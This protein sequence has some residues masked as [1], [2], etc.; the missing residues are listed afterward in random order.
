MR[1][2]PGFAQGILMAHN[3]ELEAIR[4]VKEGKKTGVDAAAA[5][6]IG[7]EKTENSETTS[8]VKDEAEG[9]GETKE[10]EK[11]D[12]YLL[13]QLQRMMAYLSTSTEKAYN[14]KDWCYSFKDEYGMPTAPGIQQDAQEYFGKLCDRIETQLTTCEP[15]NLKNLLFE[16]IF[17]GSYAE[18]LFKKNGINLRPDQQTPFYSVSVDVPKRGNGTLTKSLMTMCRGEIMSDFKVDGEIFEVVKRQLISILPNV[19]IFHLKRFELNYNTFTQ[20]KINSRF[21]FPKRIDLYPY[22]THGIGDGSGDGS[23]D[24]DGGGGGEIASSAS[25]KKKKKKKKNGTNFMVLWSILEQR[26]MAITIHLLK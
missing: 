25:P 6:E 12:D 15:K 7:V 14:P 16:N 19:C 9:G 10:K 3:D 23:G 18:Q 22:T 1:H 11:E 21:E 24:G 4:V 17:K 26:T 13:Y 20:E 5:I 8:G 2:L